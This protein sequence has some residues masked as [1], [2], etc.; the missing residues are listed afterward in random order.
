MEI[1]DRNKYKFSDIPSL[2]EISDEVNKARGEQISLMEKELYSYKVLIQDLFAYSPSDRERNIILNIAFY[3]IGEVELLEFIQNKKKLPPNILSKKTM[4]PRKFIE[5]WNDYIITYTI[6]FSNPN[7]KLIQDYMRIEEFEEK[8]E[9]PKKKQPNKTVIKKVIIEKTNEEISVDKEKKYNKEE[10]SNVVPIDKD[11]KS[12]LRGIII[13]L[14]KHSACILTGMGEFKKI[15]LEDNMSVGEEVTA[16]AK[17]GMKDYKLQIGIVIVAI[18]VACGT[19]FYK[20]SEI[21]RTIL[22]NTTSQVKIDVNS[23]NKII[24]SYSPTSKGEEML[25]NLNLNN[26]KLDKAMEEILNYA[27][28]NKMIP[29]GKILIT[30]TGDPLKYGTLEKTGEFAASHKINLVINNAGNEQKLSNQNV[31]LKGR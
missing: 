12:K 26:M 9:I 6:I 30:V 25:K 13:K 20:Y 21:D 16:R 11:S 7:Y 14:F 24:S 17:K 22:I 19:F 2:V 28:N 8:V 15:K 29:S 3:I 23:F 5:E 31:E 10:E 27:N 1:F 4:Q 18:I